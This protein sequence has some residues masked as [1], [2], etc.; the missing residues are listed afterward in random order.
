MGIH[1]WGEGLDTQTLAQG[2]INRT[3]PSAHIYQRVK[4]KFYPDSILTALGNAR[5]SR[6]SNK[7]KGL[8]SFFIKNSWD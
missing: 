6:F 7:Q 5:V 4:L 3:D 8:L 1:C 2:I